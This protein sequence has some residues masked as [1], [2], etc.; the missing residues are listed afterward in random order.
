M[1]GALVLIFFVDREYR[2]NLAWLTYPK[3]TLNTER[4]KITDIVHPANIPFSYRDQS[5]AIPIPDILHKVHR[6]T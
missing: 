4:N 6:N 3:I 2:G 1:H 5:E